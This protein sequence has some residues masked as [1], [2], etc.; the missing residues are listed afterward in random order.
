MDVITLRDEESLAELRD[1]GVTAPDIRLSADPALTLPPPPAEEVD[2]L[3]KAAGISPGERC[4]C[5]I[6][7]QWPDVER[8]FPALRAAAV[9]GYERH[10][11]T[12]LFLAV[13]RSHDPELTRR[14][15]EGLAVPCH[16]LASH[17][18][19]RAI[20]GLLGRMGLGV[21]MRLHS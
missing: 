14:L 2:N 15:A 17:L 5:F 6:V 8:T 4:A 3:L 13:E 16:V 19:H 12:P 11:L 21:S 18:D 7:R 20:I 1:M 9:Y 10:G